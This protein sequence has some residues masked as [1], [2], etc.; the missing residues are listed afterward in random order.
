MQP[1][2]NKSR[3]E[4]CVEHEVS[5]R[6]RCPVTIFNNQSRLAAAILVFTAVLSFGAFADENLSLDRAQPPLILDPAEINRLLNDAPEA[7]VENSCVEDSAAERSGSR[8]LM[9]R[10]EIRN[11]RQQIVGCW[12]VPSV[13]RVPSVHRVPTVEISLSLCP[14]GRLKLPPEVVNKEAYRADNNFRVAADSAIR[15][16]RRCQPF[17]MP[18]DNYQTWKTMVLNFALPN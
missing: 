8:R 1:I 15:A 17:E 2:A 16:I 9:T 11:F 4:S 7:K 3:C 10:E 6:G 5:E 13:Q 18:Q 12:A 14:D